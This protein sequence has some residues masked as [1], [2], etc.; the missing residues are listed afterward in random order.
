DDPHEV[1]A[2]G[3]DAE[4]RSDAELRRGSGGR[5]LWDGAH[6]G[7]LRPQGY[8]KTIRRRVAGWCPAPYAGTNRI[9]LTGLRTLRTLSAVGAPRG[10]CPT[11]RS[12]HRAVQVV[13]FAGTRP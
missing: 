6:L 11:L 13:R 10:L 1:V 7:P 2:V 5:G 4:P 12:G 3:V 9:R 8:L